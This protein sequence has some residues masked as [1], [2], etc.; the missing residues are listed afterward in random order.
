VQF[1]T[2][3]SLDVGGPRVTESAL[4]GKTWN[5]G[6][7]TVS[8]EHY[9]S[10]HV[11]G[12]P[13]PFWTENFTAYGL[14]SR[15]LIV[16]SRP[17]IIAYTSGAAAS[18]ATAPANTPSGFTAL[19]GTTCNN[20]YSIPKGQNGVG[21]TWASIIAHPGVGNQINA[22]TDAWE[23][24]IQKRDA[25]TITFD[26]RVNS[27]ASFFADGF[28]SVRPT[29]IDNSPGGNSFT[30]TVP[31]SN[32]YF[33]TGAPANVTS[34]VEYM[35]LEDQSPIVVHTNE[36]ASRYDAGFNLTLPFN[37]FGKI[38]GAQSKIHE[39]TAT[40]GSINSKN[41]SA[42]LGNTVPAVAQTN[43]SSF[44]GV[45]AYTL[46]SNVPY[47]N[48]FCDSTT[49]STCNNASTLAYITGAGSKTDEAEKQDEFGI[50]AD[51]PLFDLPAGTV[52]AAFG[53]TYTYGNYL[54]QTTG[55]NA[56][57]DQIPTFTSTASN[58][59]SESVFA[60][61]DIPLVG[62]DFTLPLVQKLDISASIRYDKYDTFGDTRNPKISASWLLGWGMSWFTSWGTSFRA[63]S[64]QE[65]TPA[66]PSLTNTA[67][68]PGVL[69]NTI[70]ICSTLNVPAVAGTIAAILNPNC[71]A[72]LNFP[73]ILQPGNGA[74]AAAFH[75][76]VSEQ[77]TPEKGKNFSGGFEFA[78]T[79]GDG[80]FGFLDGLDITMTYWWIRITNAIQGEFRL[81]GFN[82]GAMNNPAYQSAFTLPQNDP[83]FLTQV[84]GVLASPFSTLPASSAS[85]I[86]VIADTATKNIG[87]QSLDGVDFNF[88]Y[89]WT[90]GSWQGVDLGRWNFGMAGTYNISNNSADT[91]TSPIISNYTLNDDAHLQKVRTH[92][93][94]HEDLDNGSSLSVTGFWNYIGHFQPLSNPLPPACFGVG[95]PTCASYGPNFAQYTA[96]QINLQ[97]TLFVP[98]TNTFDLSIGY[99]TGNVPSSE[100]LKN[101]HFQ[102]TINNILNTFPPFEYEVSPPGG[103]K[104]HAFYTSTASPEIN[105]NGTLI[106]FVITKSF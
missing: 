41:L 81:A 28:L 57:N 29:T 103:A 53:A 60:Q 55:T 88:S 100:Y 99:D 70:G 71:S 96:P 34:I 39:Y 75:N 89:S 90:M 33:P 7:V 51:G 13:E 5:G 16:D 9:D 67:A 91:N 58:R 36:T 63:P 14:D 69:S 52:K 24:P 83:N 21:L 86:Q 8:F 18:S 61:I 80:P 35:D 30:I 22:Y 45:P 72:A 31:K 97:S 65:A 32:P 12:A 1:Q 11:A 59:N 84:Q 73:A 82:T 42:A 2:G 76:G 93:G 38:Y 6:D 98:A 17:G 94:F 54:S 50:N 4:F 106:N 87:S 3:T 10:S 95:Q 77:L 23:A 44:P 74:A 79:Q 43:G 64:F 37:W 46:P 68:E 104:P 48:P 15:Q 102:F 92:L 105:P 101:I 27:W 78:P 85:L 66:S 19:M 40:T 62:G 20:C 25:A 47:L 56:N 49:Y 26:Q